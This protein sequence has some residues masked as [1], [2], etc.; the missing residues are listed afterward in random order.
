M[1]VAPKPEYKQPQ[2]P[3]RHAV[4]ERIIFPFTIRFESGKGLNNME[5]HCREMEML[6]ENEKSFLWSR[7]LYM[8]GRTEDAED[9]LQDTIMKACRGFGTFKRD[10]NF[11]AWANRIMVN[12]HIN[13]TRQK[14]KSTVS[15]DDPDVIHKNV[16]INEIYRFA[17]MNNPENV[18]FQDHINE[19][20]LDLL[21]TLPEEHRTIFTLFH[22]EGYT[23]KEISRAVN[24]PLGTVKSRIHRARLHL[25]EKARDLSITENTVH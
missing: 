19:K 21:Y 25:S 1:N 14:M 7:A 17:D 6:L 18:F 11:R 8:T 10:T 9:L 20:I 16:F 5:Q 15:L 12:T 4:C 2:A 24:M 3:A 22:F 23:Y 13:K